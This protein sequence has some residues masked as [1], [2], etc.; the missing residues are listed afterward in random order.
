MSKIPFKNTMA[1][2]EAIW[3][4]SLPKKAIGNIERMVVSAVIKIGR[5]R[6]GP[7]IKMAW[8]NDLYDY[9]G[10]V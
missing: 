7:A 6:C 4:P 9:G 5:K 2:P 3:P 1:M 10:L 8:C